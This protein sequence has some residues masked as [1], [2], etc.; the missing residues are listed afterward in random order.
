MFLKRL[1]FLKA[2]LDNEASLNNFPV[3][4]DDEKAFKPSALHSDQGQD[5]TDY[6]SAGQ[7]EMPLA[8]T[9]GEE[10]NTQELLKL[11]PPTG[12]ERYGKQP[13]RTAH[14][15]LRPNKARNAGLINASTER[16]GAG[17]R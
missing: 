9:N 2:S 11:L 8:I 4:F 1:L 6:M 10:D 13:P 12:Y 17:G 16:A 15:K 7:E 3:P 14:Q 5:T